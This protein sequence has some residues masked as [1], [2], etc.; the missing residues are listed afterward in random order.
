MANNK[1]YWIK[2]KT[3]FFSQDTIDFLLSQK[4]GCQYVVL[5]QMLCLASANNDGFLATKFDD[6]MI[7]Y[8]VNNTTEK[9]FSLYERQRHI[10]QAINFINF[11]NPGD[12]KII[13]KNIVYNAAEVLSSKYELEVL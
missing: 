4:N 13:K 6:V 11:K 10:K 8:D 7:P 9:L 3:D 2:L 1:Y 12:T 5:Y